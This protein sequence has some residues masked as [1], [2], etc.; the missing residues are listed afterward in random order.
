VDTGYLNFCP[1]CGRQELDREVHGSPG[2]ALCKG[3]GTLFAI[4]S[5]RFGEKMVVLS[6]GKDG[7]ADTR[8][9]TAT[10]PVPEDPSVETTVPLGE[11]TK[12]G[13][14]D[15]REQTLRIAKKKPEDT[16]G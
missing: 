5:V 3:C 15:P 11:G 10:G 6:G 12:D 8:V 9:A 1:R 7:A 2:T 16:S 13:E 14:P 4:L